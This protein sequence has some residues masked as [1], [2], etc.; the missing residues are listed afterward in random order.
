MFDYYIANS[1]FV[2]NEILVSYSRSNNPRRWE[3]FHKR[4]RRFF[5]ALSAP[6]EERLA[7]CPR[8]VNT[9]QFSPQLRSAEARNR[10]CR[11]TGIQEDA[12]LIVSATR[13]SPEKNVQLLPQI[14]ERLAADNVHD[15]RLLIAGSGTEKEWLEDKAKNSDGKIVIMGQLDKSSLAELYANADVFIHPNPREPFGNVGLEAMASGAAC[16][17]PDSGG[18]LAY[19]DHSNSWLVEPDAAS[20]CEAIKEAI[21]N[22]SL[23][24]SKIANALETAAQNNEEAAVDRLLATYDRFFR[25]FSSRE[26]VKIG[27]ARDTDMNRHGL[28]RS[29]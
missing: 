27:R 22:E 19:A 8:G 16:V 17:L 10:I 26:P 14:I 13:L 18:V 9:S 29:V 7:V 21:E 15:F 6:I 23:R 3:W 11:E 12:K 2:A 1:P 28:R 4:C 25:S 24:Q 5:N 20:F